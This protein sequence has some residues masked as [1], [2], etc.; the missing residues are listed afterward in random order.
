MTDETI[1]NQEPKT[2]KT[3]QLVKPVAMVYVGRS[4]LNGRLSQFR[5]YT[6][7]IPEHLNGLIEQ[8]PFIKNLFVPVA[9]LATARQQLATKG[10]ALYLFNQKLSEVK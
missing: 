7:G 8:Y 2:K 1:E 5:V 4:A 3:K 9:E 6:D 10:S